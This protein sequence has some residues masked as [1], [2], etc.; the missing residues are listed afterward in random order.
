[1]QIVY[2]SLTGNI[3]RFLTKAA[4]IDQSI[5][6][7]PDLVMNRDFILLTSTLGF[8]EVPPVVDEFLSYHD[9]YQHLVATVGSGN[10]NWGEYYCRA[11]QTIAQRYG[12]ENIFNFELSGTTHDVD[13]F[14][15][16][17]NKY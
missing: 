5:A 13:N 3:K 6:I 7:K 10:K 2:F 15:T 9:N 8:G 1:M 17:I 11:A 12:V 4:L 14:L 16:I